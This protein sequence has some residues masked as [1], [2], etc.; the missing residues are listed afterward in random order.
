MAQLYASPYVVISLLTKE[1]QTALE[2]SWRNQPSGPELQQGAIQAMLLARRYR[3]NAWISDDQALGPLNPADAQWA[4]TMLR[5]LAQELGV[6]RFA[7]LE[8][9]DAQN[10]Q[11]LH[12]H[13]K[14]YSAPTSP[15]QLRRFTSLAQARRWALS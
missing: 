12:P 2:V 4:E 5:S 15:L 13:V 7:L 6:T 3:V 14:Q 1:Q 8:S 9:A 11:L 10:R